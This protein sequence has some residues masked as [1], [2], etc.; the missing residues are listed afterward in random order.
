MTTRHQ[1][2]ALIDVT[3]AGE[4]LAGATMDLWQDDQQH[5]QWTARVVVRTAPAAEEG[6]LTGKTRD[7]RAL[8]GHALI[9][10]RQMG[11][12]GR[13]ETLIEFH[14]AGDLHGLDDPPQPPRA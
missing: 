9:A 8:S 10:D 13:R 4:P 5:A 6:E 12:G 3:F 1:R 11:P 7:G 2:F 14:G